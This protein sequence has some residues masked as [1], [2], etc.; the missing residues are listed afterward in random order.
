MKRFGDTAHEALD[1]TALIKQLQASQVKQTANSKS[2][3]VAG[4]AA[5]LTAM[6][7]TSP[8]QGQREVDMLLTVARPEALFYVVFIAPQSEWAG[9]QPAFDAVVASLSF[10]K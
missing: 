8:L 2:V 3:K 7:S 9:V 5:L 6:E 10:T 4:Q 1:T